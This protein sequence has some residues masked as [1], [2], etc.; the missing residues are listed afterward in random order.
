MQRLTDIYPLDFV[1]I[2]TYTHRRL[3]AITHM[4]HRMGQ[5]GLRESPWVMALGKQKWK[6]RPY[7][8]K[9]PGLE[10]K[11]LP[12]HQQAIMKQPYPTQISQSYPLQMDILV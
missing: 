2:K 9:G 10:D 1:S 5:A 12:Q 7:S 6:G 8:L 4:W 11:S 3:Q